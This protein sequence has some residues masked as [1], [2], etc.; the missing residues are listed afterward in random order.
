MIGKKK[1]WCRPILTVLTR[2]GDNQAR[3][4]EACKNFFTL[5]QN[6]GLDKRHSSCYYDDIQACGG[7]CCPCQHFVYS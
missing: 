6:S 3:L 5:V 4:L 1:K 7:N 2:D